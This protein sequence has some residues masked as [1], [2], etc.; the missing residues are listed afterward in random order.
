MKFACSLYNLL[1]R[2]I[3]AV[4]IFSGEIP[5]LKERLH[6]CYRRDDT[7]NNTFNKKCILNSFESVESLFFQLSTTRLTSTESRT[8]NFHSSLGSTSSKAQYK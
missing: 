6:M 5:F 2:I 3:F 1:D 8:Y 7:S 4:F